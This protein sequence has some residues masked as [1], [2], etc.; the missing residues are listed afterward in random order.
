MKQRLGALDIQLLVPELSTALESY[1]LNNI[2]NVADSSRQFLLKFNKPDS[3][4][5]VV[6]DCGLKIYM[7]EFSR[8]IPP[9]PSGFV[10]KLR[11]HLKAKRL[12][13][14]RQVLDDRIIVLQFADGKNYLVLEFFSAGN[15][16]LLDETRKILLVQRV[17]HEHQNRV[18]ETYNMFDESLF[19]RTNIDHRM[20]HFEFDANT[21]RTWLD[22]ELQNDVIPSASGPAGEGQKRKKRSIHRVLLG[23]VPY[24]LSDLLSKRLKEKEFDP[25]GLFTDFVEKTDTISEILKDV[26]QEYQELLT[27]TENCGYIV[28]KKNPNFEPSRDQ[29]DLEYF[30]ENFHPFK[31]F[32]KEC[33][34]SI[35]HVLKIEGTY[36]RTV[37]KFFSTLESSKYAMK[38]QNQETLAGKKLEEARSENGKRIQALID[39]QS[40][41]EQKG[42]LIITHAELVEDA[43]G[44]VQG[45]LD[46][47]LDWNIIEK[48]II[49]EQKKGNKIAKA[50]KLPLKLKKNTI[51]LELPLEDNND[52]EDDTELSEEVDSSDISS[53]ELS[54]DEESDQGSTQHQ[55]RKSNR[56][57]ALKPTTVSVDIKLDLSTYANASEYFM[58]KKHTVEKQKKVEQNLDKAMK[59][60][61][62][63][64]NKQLNSKLKESH[65]VLKR[66]RTPYFFEK[67]NWF[68]SS[69]GHLVLMGK[70]DIETDQLYS[71]YI[72]PDDI[73]VSNEFGSHVWI[74]NPKKTEVPPNTIMQAGIFAMAASVAWSK[75]LSSSPYFCSASNVSKFSANDNTVLPQGCYRLIDERE[76]VVLPPAQLVM[77]LGFFWKV[78]VDDA[79]EESEDDEMEGDEENDVVAKLE[80][81]IPATHQEK[82]TD[83][84]GNS[85]ADDLKDTTMGIEK[86]I[87]DMKVS[88]DNDD[89]EEGS[90]TGSSGSIPENMSVAETIV[91][92]IKK[93]VRGKKGKLKKMQRKYRDQDENE[94]LLKLEA[95]GTLKGIEKQRKKEQEELQK[96]QERTYKKERRER[97]REQQTLQFTQ[98]KKV[99][100]NYDKFE[101]ELKSSLSNEDEILD[102]V[103]VF[104][105]WPALAKFKYKVK[106]VPGS[107][108]KTKAMTEM[109]HY[110]LNREVDTS[111]IDKLLDWPKEH[112]V[113]KTLTAQDL[114]IRLCV[115]KLNLLLPSSSKKKVRSSKGK[116]SKHNSKK[117]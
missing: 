4:I 36:N 45:L 3:K 65:K 54:S 23:H 48:L 81:E 64:V 109:L 60:I 75:K 18:G 35:L 56:I 47:Q 33:E 11:K 10:V 57:R 114:V 62:T 115:D 105:P 27:T 52:T 28:A 61:E 68:I 20:E 6:V 113:I 69:E 80:E 102:I 41:N 112:E 51:V 116:A 78:K 97:Q 16:I 15:V 106:L 86:E 72:T 108:K 89:K 32:I 117:K 8:D 67:Y 84:G 74:K 19:S 103:P 87:E 7:T 73:Y 110:F 30:F 83:D 9:V 99:K 77:G 90:A 46:Q 101:K 17:V 96:E 94:R 82:V 14:L 104:A 63:K 59:N 31:P 88:A 79:S 100:I 58:V 93:N 76:K 70:S 44:A 37:D 95:L 107:A 71:K 25:A 26:Q 21:V 50:I 98:K 39:V 43:K 49:T 13:A 42:H 38:I 29:E 111:C 1:R 66:L 5:N 40:Q 34:R 92:D 12:T 55:H 2:Y 53:S 24:F 91:G 85:V 22:A